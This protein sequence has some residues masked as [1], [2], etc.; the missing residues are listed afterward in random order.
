GQG[1]AVGPAADVWALGA[2]L[3]ELLT[4]RPPFREATVLDTLLQVRTSDPVPPS[5]LVGRL[6]RDLETICL[7]GLHKEPHRGYATAADLADDLRRFLAGEPIRARATGPLERTWRWCRRNKAAAALLATVA[8][9]LLLG[10]TVLTFLAVKEEQ[11]QD[12]L[13]RKAEAERL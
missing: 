10:S 3:Y 11:R 6:P 2:I 5:R 1:K 13:N 8:A 7:K 4:G 12:A 9:A